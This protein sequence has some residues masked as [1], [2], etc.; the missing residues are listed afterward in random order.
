MDHEGFHVFH[1]TESGRLIER[2]QELAHGVV[3]VAVGTIGQA[4]TTGCD[5]A[6]QLF[7]VQRAT[8]FAV[9]ESALQNHILPFLEQ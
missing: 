3:I 2:G 9:G 8:V 7:P 6:E 5:R 4:G 1:T